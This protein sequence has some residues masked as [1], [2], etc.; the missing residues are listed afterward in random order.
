MV[1]LVAPTWTSTLTGT[2]AAD[3]LLLLR[4]IVRA[5]QPTPAPDSITVP[6]DAAP[7]LHTARIETALT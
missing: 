3:G 2:E 5:W 4:P 6:L 7:T 1:A